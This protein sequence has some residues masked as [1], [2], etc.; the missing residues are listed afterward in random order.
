[1]DLHLAGG[2]GKAAVQEF[3][4]VEVGSHGNPGNFRGHGLVFTV[5]NEALGRGIGA[6]GRLFRQLFHAGE[7]FV[8]NREGSVRRLNQGHGVVGV[9]D[10]LVQ[11]PD[12][13]AHHF[14]NGQTGGVISGGIDAKA[15]G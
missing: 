3:D 13:R 14:P 10:P 6:R 9:A 2:A 1:M 5:H 11:H 15:R 8:N 12:V 4:A 7:F